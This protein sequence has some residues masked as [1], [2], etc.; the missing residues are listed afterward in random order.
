ME[1]TSNGKKQD[2]LSSCR[3]IHLMSSYFRVVSEVTHIEI[4]AAQPCLSLE[5]NLPEPIGS[6]DECSLF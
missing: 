5:E 4:V 1:E 6:S 3:H 2:L